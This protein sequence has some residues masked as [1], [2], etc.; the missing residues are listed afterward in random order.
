MLQTWLPEC[1]I[2]LMF[3][4]ICLSCIKKYKAKKE[5]KKETKQ[6]NNLQTDSLS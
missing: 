5:K 2:I 1:T 3:N 6:I 4:I